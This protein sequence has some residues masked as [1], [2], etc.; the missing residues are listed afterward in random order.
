MWLSRE[1]ALPGSGDPHL[2]SGRMVNVSLQSTMDSPERST[3]VCTATPKD[4]GPRP[5]L[6]YTG[7]GIDFHPLPIKPM[8]MSLLDEIRFLE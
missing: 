7:T 3:R 4:A 6:L 1:L 2:S 5:S 8:F